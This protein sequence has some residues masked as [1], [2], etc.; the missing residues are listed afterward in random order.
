MKKF[1]FKTSLLIIVMFSIFLFIE[2]IVLSSNN[3]QMTFKNSLLK[4][5]GVEVIILGN[6]HSFYGINPSVSDYKMINVANK[7]RKLET[8]YLILK[9][10]INIL[11][12]IKSIIIP[13]SHYTLLADKVLQKEKR[14]YYNYFN[15]KSYD[16]GF[17]NNNLIFNEP[18]RE[19]IDNSIF[20]SRDNHDL[21]ISDLGWR[22]TSR[23]YKKNI[24][25][26]KDRINAM[27][28]TYKEGNKIINK[29]IK[30]LDSIS[31]LSRTYNKKIFFLTPPYHPDYYQ[32]SNIIYHQKI[33]TIINNF[34]DEENV[35]LINGKE[36]NI[37][38]NI[39]FEDIDHLNLK[40]ARLFTKKIDSILKSTFNH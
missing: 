9:Q 19:L 30:Y 10:N 24:T 2:T 32:Y 37:T 6:S 1:L 15:L 36:L 22:T 27:E 26:I 29:N 16:Q 25:R 21:K 20:G 35:Y 4:K 39:F 38:E 8:D 40:G 28:G 7:G 18:F 3:N 33:K 13:I 14:L 17:L 12:D 34:T 5:Q 11:P 23:T 31:Q